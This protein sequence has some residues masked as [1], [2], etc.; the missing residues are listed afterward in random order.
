[1]LFQNPPDDIMSSLGN[2]RYSRWRPRWLSNKVGIIK[3]D[4]TGVFRM[5]FKFQAIK[6]IAEISNLRFM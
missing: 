3:Q 4:T 6:C 5:V 1:M 2:L